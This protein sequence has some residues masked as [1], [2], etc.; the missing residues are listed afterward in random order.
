MASYSVDALVLSRKDIGE[1]DRLLTIFS[2][3]MGK[4]RVVAKGVRR[5]T[6]RMSAHLEPGRESRLFLIDRRSLPLVTQVE[7]KQIFTSTAADLTELK[8][9][10]AILETTA[11]LLDDGQRDSRL[12]DLVVAT[13]SAFNWYHQ[14]PNSTSAAALTIAFMLKA[15]RLLG[16]GLETQ[17]CVGCQQLLTAPDHC[18]HEFYLS[19]THGGVLHSK[20]GHVS[21]GIYKINSA[22]L[23][24]LRELTQADL[25]TI[26]ANTYT[27]AP[28]VLR[29]VQAL[30]EWHSERSL[31]SAEL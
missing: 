12:Y 26:A 25:A 22:A 7:P 4:Q 11:N 27:A 16:F 23:Q 8:N 29:P 21:P 31:K 15:L 14:K 6:S 30:V 20:C 2:R 3:T 9:L 19:T 18:H 5:P 1:A 17:Y 13:L 10:Y 28:L 24:T